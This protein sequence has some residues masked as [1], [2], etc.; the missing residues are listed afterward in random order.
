MGDEDQRMK[1][2]ETQIFT[3]LHWWRDNKKMQTDTIYTQAG[4]WGNEAQVQFNSIQFSDP[5][6]ES[7][8]SICSVFSEVRFSAPTMVSHE[9][10]QHGSGP[11]G[12]WDKPSQQ[13]LL[14]AGGL[15]WNLDLPSFAPRSKLTV[16]S[17]V[18][19][20]ERSRISPRTI[21]EAVHGKSCMY[22]CGLYVATYF[23][24]TPFCA[25]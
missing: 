17:L 13:F 23:C 9:L 24:F 25:K 21:M 19:L 8:V 18:L 3:K 5:E 6:A 20:W 7:E 14:S 2:R 11:A 16:T 12:G 1:S 22:T 10:V 4:A 15:Q